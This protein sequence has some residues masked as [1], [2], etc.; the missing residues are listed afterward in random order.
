MNISLY[1]GCDEEE[2]EPELRE[3]LS[4]RSRPASCQRQP[5]TSLSKLDFFGIKLLLLKFKIR[6]FE[7][8][9]LAFVTDTVLKGKLRIDG[10][11]LRIFFSKKR[12]P[13][14]RATFQRLL[15]KL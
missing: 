3:T 2:F 13:D 10:K 7:I 9:F 1:L 11:N 14:I 15:R 5:E 4:T 6:L 12:K 8:E